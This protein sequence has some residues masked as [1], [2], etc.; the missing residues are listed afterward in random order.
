MVNKKSLVPLAPRSAKREVGSVAIEGTCPEWFEFA[1]HKRAK[2]AEGFTLIETVISVG[3]ISILIPVIF[4]LFFISLRSELRMRILKS[5][6]SNGDVALA[7]ISDSIREKAFKMIDCTT[8]PMA[9]KPAGNYNSQST[10]C[11]KTK[12]N[13]CFRIYVAGNV[14]ERAIM[15][16]NLTSIS[17]CANFLDTAPIV[18]TNYKDAYINSDKIFKSYVPDSLFRT[19]S[20]T[21]DFKIVSKKDPQVSLDYYSKAKLRNY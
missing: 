14:G 10:V 5:V 18:L 11:F 19:G 1:H 3:I 20:V 13:K 15:V 7:Y 9:D 16:D 6:K 2:R 17:G 21:T 8:S 12:D 4:N